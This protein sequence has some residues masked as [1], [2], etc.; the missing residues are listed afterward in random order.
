MN[1]VQVELGL[2]ATGEKK[3]S[4]GH[5]MMP[6]GHCCANFVLRLNANRCLL[7]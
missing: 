2:T 4:H 1:A 6:S 5:H 7:P 3:I